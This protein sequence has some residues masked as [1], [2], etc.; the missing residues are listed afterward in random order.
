MEAS[1]SA[2]GPEP[3]RLSFPSRADQ[4][5]AA[6]RAVGALGR[7][8]GIPQDQ[9]YDL[10]TIATEACMNVARHAYGDGEGRIE[11]SAEAGDGAITLI[12]RDHGAGIRPRPA[13][14]LSEGARLG[15]LLIATLASK[16]EITTSRDTGTQ[17]KATLNSDQV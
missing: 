17:V 3:V 6:R 13:T 2:E 9:I 8:A 4:V 14:S 15:L 1:E 12:V 5:V 16:V 7:A 11:L 10:E